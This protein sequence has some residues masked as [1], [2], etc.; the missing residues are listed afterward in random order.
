MPIRQLPPQLI[1][2]IAAGEVVERP[3]VVVKELVENSLDAGATHIKL[4][5]AKGGV[6]LIS[7]SDN[8][9]GI[10]ADEIELA[11]AR[12]ATSKITG[13]DDLHRI[14][15]YG[16]RGEALPSIASVSRL[17]LYTR[18]RGDEVGHCLRAYGDSPQVEP[19]D[20]PVGT[21][22]EVRDLFYNVP[23]RRRFL[24]TERTETAHIKRWMHRLL[25]AA[26]KV[27]FEFELDGKPAFKLPGDDAER[28]KR[29]LETVLGSVF[30]EQSVWC[31]HSEGG[32][33]LSGWLGSPNIARAQA[34]WQYL[35]VNGRTVQDKSVAHAVKTGYRDVL[36]H[37]RQ[38]CYALFLEIDP[39]EVDVNAHPV[40]LEVRFR[41]RETVHRFVRRAVE[42][43][44]GEMRPGGV[45][46]RIE[47]HGR[48]ITPTRPPT[49]QS[50]FDLASAWK[51]PG[52][53]PAPDRRLSESAAAA[54][55]GATERAAVAPPERAEAS[56]EAGR[57]GMPP[58]GF[59]L[60]Q[61]HGIYIIAQNAE[62]MVVVDM[63][64]AHERITYER[65]KESHHR[66][67]VARQM[68]LV[69]EAVELTAAETDL[70]EAQA[71]VLE[72]FGI[73][74]SRSGEK[75]VVLRSVPSLLYGAESPKMLRDVLAD[76]GGFGESFR[77]EQHVDELL[78]TLACHTAYRANRSLTVAE[79]NALLRDMEEVERSG[80][81]NHGR[82]TWIQFGI[83][84]LDKLFLRGR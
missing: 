25:L 12:H 40:K 44:V 66:G 36:Y 10:P 77:L 74:T 81:C 33:R 58:L 24:K 31:D 42:R 71:G 2:Q 63:H 26:D 3:A 72:G 61:L 82:P 78:S 5:I 60:C 22:V 55:A 19:C 70:C 38:P 9:S 65:L 64:A 49:A 21:T 80:Q 67:K 83:E 32:L 39:G 16:F 69:P 53:N 11:L 79:M 14:V 4:R 6:G 46:H 45:A 50:D 8:G 27:G 20:H 37:D 73:E 75:G 51:T 62:G 15:S 17:T 23:A 48:G 76:L 29:G 18:C 54:Y 68:L 84:Q 52:A 57:D 28:R 47:H 35:Y 56:P 7:V 13:L 59:A 30:A 41:E 34:D 43:A 1:N